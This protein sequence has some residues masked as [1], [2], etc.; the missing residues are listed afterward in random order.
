[1]AFLHGEVVI[2]Q[3]R[4]SKDPRIPS[5]KARPTAPVLVDSV[6]VKVDDLRRSQQ[7]LRCVG[8]KNVGG[9][10]PVEHPPWIG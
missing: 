2:Q 4:D 3:P 10:D 6:V 5:S 9:V 7:L 1:M 8:K